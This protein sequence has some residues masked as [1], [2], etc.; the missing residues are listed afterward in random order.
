MCD[1]KWGVERMFAYRHP[2]ASGNQLGRPF[3]FRLPVEVRR[4]SIGPRLADG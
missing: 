4:I 1:V 3:W 2:S